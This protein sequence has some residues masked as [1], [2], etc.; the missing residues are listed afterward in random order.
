MKYFINEN[1]LIGIQGLDK[2]L[3]EKNNGPT[4]ITFLNK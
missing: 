4:Q 1:N 2:S 3:I